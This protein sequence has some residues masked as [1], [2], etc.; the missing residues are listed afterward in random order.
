VDRAGLL[1][2]EVVV[3]ADVGIEDDDALA[4]RL[5]PEQSFFD[6][7]VERVVDGGAGGCKR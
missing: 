2:D 4:D 6:Q 5:R 3:A 1:V 7:Q